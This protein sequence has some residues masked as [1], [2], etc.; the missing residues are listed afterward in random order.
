[1]EALLN[2]TIP[3]NF[4]DWRPGD[5]R[6]Y[7]SNINRVKEELEWEPTIDPLSGVEGLLQ[8]VLD[9]LNLLERVLK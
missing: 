9:H 3:V 7:I 8:W 5:Q 6:I 4:A 1:L 2:K